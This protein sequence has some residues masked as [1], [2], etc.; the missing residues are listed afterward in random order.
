MRHAVHLIA[1]TFALIAAACA[2]PA[3]KKTGC[4]A[5]PA[6][7]VAACVPPSTEKPALLPA[8]PV[9]PPETAVVTASA[10]LHG[11]AEKGAALV[12]KFECNRC[13]EGV[14]TAKVTF[15]QQCVGCHENI[16]TGRF[17][18][19]TPKIGHWKER[20][21]PYRYAPSL[22]A[23][24]KRF[25]ADWLARFIADPNDLRPHLLSTMPRMKLTGA[26]A[27]DI[28]AYLTRGA[29]PEPSEDTLAGGDPARGRAI[30]EAKGCGSCHEFTGVPA[31]PAKPSETATPEAQ[32]KAVLVAP[33][34]RHTRDRFRR[35]ALVAWLLDPPSVK[36]GTPM[37]SHGFTRAEA[38][39]VAA[40]LTRAELAPVTLA[41][42]LPRLPLLERT[43]SYKEV[44]ERVLSV[45]CRH[46]HG[47]PDVAGGDGGPGNTGGF[48][49][50][51]RRI[52]LS[53]YTSAAS[54]Y[55]AD[56][57]ERHSLFE[58][59]RDGTPL[60]VAALD[61][62]RHEEAGHPVDGVRG[63]PLGL[64]SLSRHDIQLVE[65]WIARGR[66]R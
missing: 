2:P 14:S 54:G 51:P 33:D 21:A 12:T 4:A 13:H 32:R 56:D 39:D 30:V 31:L 45:T 23:A 27:A 22:E 15:D 66:P 55:V 25:R 40:Y 8:I 29:P 62:R 65:T 38:T 26:Q 63:M 7:S 35:D 42:V 20:V 61:A 60:I 18:A 46:C 16:A 44:E 53:T 64:P 24:G 58:K 47:N 37:P 52:D 48:G 57:H 19:G 10:A 3:A 59:T 9:T 6:G 43:V 5:G 36:P 41:T 1:A 49:F 50:E 28:A 17:G 11:D 34:L